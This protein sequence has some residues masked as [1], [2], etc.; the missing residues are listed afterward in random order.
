M[1]IHNICLIIHLHFDMNLSKR[2]EVREVSLSKRS[3]HVRKYR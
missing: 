2:T 3:L 1:Y